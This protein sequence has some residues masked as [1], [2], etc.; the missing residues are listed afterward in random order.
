MSPCGQRC[1][2]LPALPALSV[3]REAAGV[4]VAQPSSHVAAATP[5]DIVA[6]LCGASDQVLWRSV[7]IGR[8]A[9]AL[10]AARE[11][12][13]WCWSGVAVPTHRVVS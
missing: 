3:W 11:G 2:Y 6:L 4:A 12:R 8:L 13:C 9:L 10:R 7:V 5:S 1:R